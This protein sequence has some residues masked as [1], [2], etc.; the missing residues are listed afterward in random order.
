M[1]NL[2]E[3][4]QWDAGIYK[5]EITDKVLGGD[6]VGDIDNKQAKS[7]GN[8]TKYLRAQ[9]EKIQEDF[10]TG[11]LGGY[12]TGDLIVL[13]GC[14]ISGSTTKAI[15]AGAIFYNGQV[16][17]V[18]SASGI[19][20][21]S[22]WVFAIK[23]T[24]DPYQIEFKGGNT[25]TGIAD[26]DAATIKSLKGYLVN[27]GG[28]SSFSTG[29]S[30][31]TG[32]GTLFKL[33]PNGDVDLSLNIVISTGGTTTVGAVPSWAIPANSKKFIVADYNGTD[34]PSELCVLTVGSNI[35]LLK[36]SDGTKPSNRSAFS[37][38]IRYNIYQ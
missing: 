8:R 37:I 20:G 21:A 1:A 14:V 23:N 5:I 34:G 16:Y 35:S 3:T 28:F 26:W 33:Y 29:W 10:I 11:F 30:N 36:Q 32:S 18:A 17:K 4:N 12:T 31:G 7:L 24:V 25:G 13:H 19:T 6:G 9:L 15:T 2:T 27:S 22:T 38:D